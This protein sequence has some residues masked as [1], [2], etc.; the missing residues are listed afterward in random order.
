[1]SANANLVAAVVIGLA[2][3]SLIAERM[4]SAFPASQMPEAPGLRRLLLLT[5]VF[6]GV[7]GVAEIGRSVGLAWVVW[8][9][10]GLA[11]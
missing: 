8:I 10:R 9:E 2:F 1:M 7:T 4:M 6:L 5:T 11:S 3:P